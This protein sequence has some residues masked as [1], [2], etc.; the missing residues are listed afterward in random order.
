MSDK[1]RRVVLEDLGRFVFEDVER[2][3]PGPGEALIRVARVGICGSDISAYYG[4]HPYIHCP[5]VLGH[6]FSGTVEAVGPGV[7]GLSAGTGCTVI[8]HLVCG[9]CPACRRQQYNLCGQLRVLGAQA[10]GAFAEYIN[11]PAEMVMPVPEGVPMEQAALVEPAAVGYH[12]ARHGEPGANDTA[13]VF[14][15]GPIGMF[16]MQ[17]VKALGPKN[18]FIVDKDPWRLDLARSLGVDGAIDL[19]SEALDQ[20]LERL[21]GG[22]DGID[23][24]YDCVGFGGEALGEIIRVARR[25]VRVVVAGVLHTDCVVPRLCDFI[26]HELTLIGSTMYVPDDFRAVVA[27]MSKG[28][29]RTDGIITHSAP[30]AEVERIYRMIDTRSERFF[31]IMLSVGK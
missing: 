27:L 7:T 20:G 26:E 13:L 8:P 25:G 10:D 28:I 31:K 22:S 12:A 17:C 23:L 1:M 11:V 2:P 9:E 21:A 4:R 30:L 18:V 29:I 3:T 24:F 19:S 15:A 16:T 14:G 5:I 6:E